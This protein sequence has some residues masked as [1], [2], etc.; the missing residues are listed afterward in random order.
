MTHRRVA[1]VTGGSRGIGLGIAHALASEGWNLVVNGMRPEEQVSEALEK[2]R[3]AGGEVAYV[4]GNVANGDDRRRLV[5][6]I[7]NRF[8]QL[9]LLVNNAGITSP[10]RKDLLEATRDSFEQV[11]AVNF[12]GPA[13]LAQMCAR[14]MREQ[15]VQDP[16]YA[17]AIV[18]MSSISAEIPSVNRGD[19]CLSRAVLSAAGLQ[20][21]KRLSGE[22]VKVFE[23]RPGVIRTDMTAAVTEKYDRLIADGLTAERRWGEP[24]D[25]G[26]AVA[27]LVREGS[28]FVT[29]TL[30][31]VD[32][33]LTRLRGL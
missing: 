30:I 26:R 18:N 6:Q 31:L 10:G 11:F 2:L 33:G 23:I 24:Q 14:W 29:G 32:G 19:Y 15:R 20:W 16:Q 3:D 13:L 8:G 28:P 1:L 22:G 25:V 17:G 9:H 21:A 7:R 4:P 12:K 27:T 5:E